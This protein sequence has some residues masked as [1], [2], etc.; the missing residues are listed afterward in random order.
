MGQLPRM[1]D[2]P[3]IVTRKDIAIRSVKI[4]TLVN[5]FEGYF[6]NRVDI[7]LTSEQAK[8]LKSVL[9]G[10]QSKYTKLSNGKE[11]SNGAD[12]IKWI[13]EEMAVPKN[14]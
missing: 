10:L 6:S 13:L 8:T 4:P 2:Q 1:T 14:G 12:A 9:F 3:A 5:T 11:I 7:T